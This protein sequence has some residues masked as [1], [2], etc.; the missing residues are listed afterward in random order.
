MAETITPVVHGG[1]KFPYWVSVALHVLGAT[2]ASA[3]FGASLGI[4]G[5]L[6]GAPWGIAGLWVLASIALL[7]ALREG[8]KLPIPVFD[9]RR[10]V[11][12]WWR[13]FYSPPIAAL[14]YG[15]G[16]GVGF[17]T[18]LTFGTFVAVTAGALLSGDALTGAVVC[19][20]FGLARALSILVTARVS[21]GEGAALIVERLDR[22]GNTAAPRLANAAVLLA[23]LVVAAI[24]GG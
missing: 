10:Q 17:L 9:R 16:L 15:L 1:R 19:A 6:L 13:T 8:L 4:V 11:P 3:T 7:Y 14:L 23:L 20:P 5:G 2:A 24:G 18:F 12:E 21:S 22:T